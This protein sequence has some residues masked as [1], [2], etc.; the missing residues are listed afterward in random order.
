MQIFAAGAVNP[1]EA[2]RYVHQVKRVNS[3]LFGASSKSHILQTKE[4]I[5]RYY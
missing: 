2:I 4:L 3:I 5:E 1:K